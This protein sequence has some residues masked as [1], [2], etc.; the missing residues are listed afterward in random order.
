MEW[1]LWTKMMGT[2][3]RRRTEARARE[4]KRQTKEKEK[5]AVVQLEREGARGRGRGFIEIRSEAPLTF[6]FLVLRGSAHSAAGLDVQPNSRLCQ[7]HGPRALNSPLALLALTASPLLGLC[8]T[9]CRLFRFFGVF[10]FFC[11]L[12]IT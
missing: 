12:F 8:G 7:Y 1:D 5:G 3:T 6:F 2:R 10:F 4:G 9:C 11:L